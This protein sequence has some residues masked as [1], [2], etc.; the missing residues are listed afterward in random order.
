VKFADADLVGM[1]MQLI[2]GRRGSPRGSSSG[3][4]R[5]TGDRDELPLDTAVATIAADVS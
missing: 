2:V 3:K 4:C 1:P 5:A